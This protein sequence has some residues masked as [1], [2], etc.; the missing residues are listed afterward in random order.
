MAPPPAVATAHASQTP[1]HP[2]V[3]AIDLLLGA[4]HA[5]HADRVR[6]SGGRT[7]QIAEGPRKYTVG[8]PLAEEAVERIAEGILPAAYID[9]LEEIGATRIKVDGFTIEAAYA[10]NALTLE[11][12]RTRY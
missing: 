12:I 4:L 6:L 2:I 7:P 5:R 9:A 10:E 11:I 3:E 8:G 1:T